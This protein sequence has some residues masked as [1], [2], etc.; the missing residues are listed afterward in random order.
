MSTLP[1][2]CINLN[3]RWHS[4]VLFEIFALIVE[5]LYFFF[6]TQYYTFYCWIN[7]QSDV[8]DFFL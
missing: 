3:V 8:F 5:I 4:R 1:A 7:H 2:L 6:S